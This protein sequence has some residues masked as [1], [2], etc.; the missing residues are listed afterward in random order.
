MIEWH[1]KGP[2]PIEAVLE[3]NGFQLLSFTPG[4]PNHG[5]IYAWRRP[6][7]GAI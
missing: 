1:E 4:A 2:G 6:G 7:R 3:K 5:M